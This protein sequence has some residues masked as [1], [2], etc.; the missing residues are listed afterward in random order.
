MSPAIFLVF[1]LG[2][3][4]LILS[5]RPLARVSA[6]TGIL[7]SLRVFGPNA[8]LSRHVRSSSF[9]HAVFL[10]YAFLGNPALLYW[11]PPV[12]TGADGVNNYLGTLYLVLGFL[13]LIE[14]GLFSMEEIE[15]I[16]SATN[17]KKLG[18]VAFG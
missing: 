11:I 15:S 12:V 4:E 17:G 18:K 10:L 5:P 13:E 14:G 1:G 3:P 6:F 2:C 8:G 7:F 16:C 9:G